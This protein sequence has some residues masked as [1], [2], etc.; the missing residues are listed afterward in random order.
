MKEYFHNVN[1]PEKIIDKVFG[2]VD[3]KHLILSNPD[4]KL[5]I[6]QIGA[7]SAIIAHWTSN[8]ETSGIISLPTGIGKTDTMLLLI[9]KQAILR[10]LIVVPSK[11][12]RTQHLETFSTWGQLRKQGIIADDVPELR[13]TVIDST[14][15]INGNINVD[16]LKKKIEDSN[17]I[18]LTNQIFHNLGDEINEFLTESCDLLILDEAHHSSAATWSRIEKVFLK[19]N[20]KVLKFTATPFR[21]DGKNLLGKLI[22]EYSLERAILDGL[23]Q[24]IEFSLV[25]YNSDSLICKNVDEAIARSSI[26]TLEDYQRKYQNSH[27][28]MI[29]RGD[30]INHIKY[31]HETIYAKF[32]NHNAVI[33]H[34][35][36]SQ[37]ENEQAIDKLKRY[38]ADIVICVNMINEGMDFPSL[39]IAAIHSKHKTIPITIQFIGRLARLNTNIPKATVI[40]NAILEDSKNPIHNLYRD[41]VKINEEIPKILADYN[42]NNLSDI[43]EISKLELSSSDLDVEKYYSSCRMMFFKVGNVKLDFD[44]IQH[45]NRYLT[46]KIPLQKSN[47]D[48]DLINF[49]EDKFMLIVE[50]QVGTAGWTSQE[51]FQDINW[52][53]YLIYWNSKEGTICVGT[54][55]NLTSIKRLL[56]QILPN[57]KEKIV[58]MNGE[59]MFRAVDFAGNK[60]QFNNITFKQLSSNNIRSKTISGNID[61]NISSTYTDDSIKSSISIIFDN[62]SRKAIGGISK[63]GV[64]WLLQKMDPHSWLNLSVTA[65]K[66][67]ADS[68]KDTSFNL[69]TPIP[70]KIEAFPTDY[71]PYSIDVWW[72]S[73]SSDKTDEILVGDEKVYVNDLVLKVYNPNNSSTPSSDTLDFYWD[74]NEYK[75]YVF[76]LILQQN[77]LHV[78]YIGHMD[79][80]SENPIL[81]NRDEPTVQNGDGIED[82]SQY[83]SSNIRIRYPHGITIMEGW[84]YENNLTNAH[85]NH[86]K[87]LNSYVD[88]SNVNFKQESLIKKN[89]KSDSKLKDDLNKESDTN[90]EEKKKLINKK[91]V[92]YAVMEAKLA[93]LTKKLSDETLGYSVIYNDDGGHEVADIVSISL[94][95]NNLT[96]EFFHCKYASNDD[97]DKEHVQVNSLYEVCIQ[98]E[99]SVRY[100]K[101]VDGLLSQLLNR[102][103]DRIK[104]NPG[105]PTLEKRFHL[106]NINS[107]NTIREKIKSITNLKINYMIYAVQPGLSIDKLI[108]NK[109]KF[110]NVY[111]LLKNVENTLKDLSNVEFF[112]IGS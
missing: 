109:D 69:D 4:T 111:Q 98:S 11:E 22:Y 59:E 39:K 18:I 36:N 91:S 110:L 23:S 34:S 85:F 86:D 89:K 80:S 82:L 71:W 21:E 88:W 87:L 7:Y 76:R 13:C 50:K 12:L 53:S 79:L 54:E 74:F 75:R 83:I 102:H 20:K 43:F 105:D 26:S 40:S 5:R 17:V 3:D 112:V 46:S 99:R 107:F 64:I 32:E 51:V 72:N 9:A 48:H 10:T 42:K 108:R 73:N 6:P 67:T 30:N 90:K 44:S 15:K 101:N 84:L 31:L 28:I 29:V 49:D 38:K 45:N 94:I 60:R 58:R 96:I 27:P 103:N 66:M 106:G 68:S 14:P 92:Q 2:C 78:T 95:E 8:P 77:H 97:H 55:A 47:L 61:E 104:N 33:V 35:Q 63:S 1:L 16:L 81:L 25:E 65:L 41:G 57:Y 56:K 70:K 52:V 19:H 62:Q 100:T 37:K 93:T 24:E